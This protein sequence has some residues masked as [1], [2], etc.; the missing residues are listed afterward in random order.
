MLGG[1][2]THIDARSK[3]LGYGPIKATKKKTKVN[4]KSCEKF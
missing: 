4:V 1:F 2:A 3:F